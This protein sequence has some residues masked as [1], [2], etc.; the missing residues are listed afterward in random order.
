VSLILRRP[1]IRIWQMLPSHLLYNC[2]YLRSCI[3]LGRDRSGS[4]C[5]ESRVNV[6]ETERDWSTPRRS[7]RRASLLSRAGG[8]RAVPRF[9]WHGLFSYRQGS[10]DCR[11]RC[12]RH[13][14][15]Q[16]SGR[17]FR[18][19]D[20]RLVLIGCLLANSLVKRDLPIWSFG[21]PEDLE[22][23]YCQYVDIVFRVA[24]PINCR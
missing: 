20:T 1:I 19:R 4:R 18:I 6:I 17:L 2:C 5:G 24:E 8:T 14:S 22:S 13:D 9:G 3:C 15:L 12:S 10:L 7:V 16:T 11:F 23:Q 21:R